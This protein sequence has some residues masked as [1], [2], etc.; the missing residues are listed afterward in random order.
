MLPQE[1]RDAFLAALRDPNSKEAKELLDSAAK[2]EDGNMGIPDVLPWWEET[3]DDI[4]EEDE[5]E[6]A[7]PPNMVSD[8]VVNAISPLSGVGQKLIYNAL[9]IA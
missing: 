1:H 5:S 6:V 7:S 9:S 8:E 3:V 2:D 4:G